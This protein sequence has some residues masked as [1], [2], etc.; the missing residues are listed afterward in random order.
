MTSGHMQF[1]H[2]FRFRNRVVRLIC[3][4]EEWSQSRQLVLED[5][6]AATQETADGVPDWRIEL[7]ASKA[8][9]DRGAQYM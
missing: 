4:I 1:E 7:E 5:V 3:S 9:F 6:L 8:A 2:V